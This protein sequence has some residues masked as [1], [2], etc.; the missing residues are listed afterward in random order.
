MIFAIPDFTE[1]LCFRHVYCFPVTRLSGFYGRTAVFEKY[2]RTAVFEKSDAS[3]Q[4]K[5]YV[6]YPVFYVMLSFNLKGLVITSAIR[7][8]TP[9]GRC[10]DQVQ[11]KASTS[12]YTIKI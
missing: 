4:L 6:N 11:I 2:G 10:Y 8:I 7:H 9:G 12:Q 5:F 3:V 1:F